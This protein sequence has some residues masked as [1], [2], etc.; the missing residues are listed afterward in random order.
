MMDRETYFKKLEENYDFGIEIMKR[1]NHDY[2]G[3]SDPFKNFKAAEIIGLTVEE[4]IMLRLSDKFARLGNLLKRENLV[5]DESFADTAIDAMNYLNILLVYVCEK[6]D[7]EMSEMINKGTATPIS[8]GPRTGLC[9]A[10]GCINHCVNAFEK[11]CQD[12]RIRI[13]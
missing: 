10:S 9:Q 12:H 3:V 8:N 5:K 1:K 11:F 2:A 7:Q 13:A 4:G 6:L